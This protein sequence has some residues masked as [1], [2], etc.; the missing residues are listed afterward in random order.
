MASSDKSIRRQ[1]DPG[2]EMRELKYRTYLEELENRKK[3]RESEPEDSSEEKGKR[4]EALEIRIGGRE[5]LIDVKRV[6]GI[7]EV[8]KIK[9]VP[10]APEF[11]RGIV[12]LRGEIFTIIDLIKYAELTTVST[13]G[14]HYVVL[15]DSDHIQIG[16]VVAEHLDFK[17]L[18]MET[19][20]LKALKNEENVLIT[21]FRK[22]DQIL[23][24]LHPDRLIQ[25]M[26]QLEFAT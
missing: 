16:V 17:R 25:E 8:I 2:F 7:E 21:E 12:H 26:N 5:Y 14:E 22:K 11:I 3:Q 20:D 24:L 4:L 1:F 10:M 6:K 23:Y 9:H 13:V 19:N 15:F 18:K